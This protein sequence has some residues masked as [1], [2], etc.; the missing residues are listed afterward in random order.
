ME[1]LGKTLMERGF[2]EM[3]L[4][5]GDMNLCTEVIEIEM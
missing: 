5:W 1:K 2:S 3:G 4:L